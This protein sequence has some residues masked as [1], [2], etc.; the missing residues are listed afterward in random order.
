M[1]KNFT[2]KVKEISQG[3]KGIINYYK[4]LNNENHKNHKEK[5]QKI[6]LINDDKFLE[7]C[8]IS[9]KKN[10]LKNSINGKGGKPITNYSKSV[11]FCFPRDLSKD[12]TDEKIK[13]ISLFLY[14]D[15][16]GFLGISKEELKKYVFINRHIEEKTHINFIISNSMN[17]TRIRKLKNKNFLSV[18]KKS[19]NLHIDSVLNVKH[20]EY[21]PKEQKP[22]KT[23]T[24][25]LN[26]LKKSIKE[27]IQKEFNLKQKEI[28]TLVKRF[29]NYLNRYENQIKENKKIESQ[30]TLK[31]I[32]ETINK[33]QIKEI[34]TEMEN[35]FSPSM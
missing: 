28:D 5:T 8:I 22:R 11:R 20:T 10:D 35:Y 24:V 27:D 19:F 21:I 33:V 6:L 31:H 29:F 13:K 2:V 15:L 12:L 32:R 26:R 9:N 25:F 23:P 30:I 14:K 34:K 3:E 7:N 4:Y 1:I 17:E 18:I 16:A